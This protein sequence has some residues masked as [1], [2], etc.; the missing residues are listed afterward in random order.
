MSSKQ[1]FVLPVIESCNEEPRCPDPCQPGAR[2]GQGFLV[3][4]DQGGQCAR[5]EEER[6]AIGA[7]GA[8]GA[9]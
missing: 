7:R 6:G 2:A 5:A 1:R 8:R 3:P 9:G 4:A